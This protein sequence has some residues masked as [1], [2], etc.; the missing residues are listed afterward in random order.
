MRSTAL[1]FTLFFTSLVAAAPVTVAPVSA[2]PSA[3][4]SNVA[5]S[6]SPAPSAADIVAPLADI[7]PAVAVH[8]QSEYARHFLMARNPCTPLRSLVVAVSVA[9]TLKRAQPSIRD[10]SIHIYPMTHLI[11]MTFTPGIDHKRNSGNVLL[12]CTIHY[13]GI[14][15]EKT[16]SGIVTGFVDRQA[17]ARMQM[18]QPVL[19]NLPYR[20]QPLKC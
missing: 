2:I 6:G 9:A 16:L 19:V 10:I 14:Q 3:S 17:K 1:V 8:D 20:P 15:N 7:L 18:L 13:A 11:P 5:T 12:C 4:V